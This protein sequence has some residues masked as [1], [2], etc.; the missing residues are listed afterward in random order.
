MAL[1]RN[2]HTQPAIA[3]AARSAGSTAGNQRQNA[4]SLTCGWQPQWQY[5]NNVEPASEVSR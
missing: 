2:P 1:R 3:A 5:G 4:D